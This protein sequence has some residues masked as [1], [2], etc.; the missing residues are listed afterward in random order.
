LH[1][2]GPGGDVGLKILDKARRRKGR[3][4]GGREGGESEEGEKEVSDCLLE[5]RREK[6]GEG[7][8]MRKKKRN[9]G[10]K[11]LKSQ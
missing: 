1:R 3:G 11:H 5:E 8:R 7:G 4:E 9:K 6:G 2:R 10:E